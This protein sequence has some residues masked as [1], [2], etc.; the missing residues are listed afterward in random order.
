MPGTSS[1][2][3]ERI[4]GGY[5]LEIVPDRAQLARYGLMVGDVQDVIAIGARRRDRDDDRRGP[6]A[7]RRQTSAIRA[8]CAAT[9]RRSRARCWCR[10][11]TVA[12][13]PLGE[14]ANVRLTRGADLDPHRE[15]A[16]RRLHLRRHRATAI[17]AA[18]SPRREKPW[19]SRSRFPPGYYVGL[20]RAVRILRARQSAAEDRR[21]A[22]AALIILLLLYLNFRRMTE[23]LIVML[24]L[25]FA[26]VGGIWLM[27]WLGFNL[28]SRS[29]SASSRW[30]ASRQKPASSC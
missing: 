28:R 27:W 24:S 6:R 20:E 12:P 23:T 10:S 13:V 16:A 3:A 2:Y 29:R 9:P 25:P 26:L 30:P 17:S 7:L 8:T 18:M 19:P 5:Y 15:C 4:I 14:V 21:A 11:L 1:A 22:D